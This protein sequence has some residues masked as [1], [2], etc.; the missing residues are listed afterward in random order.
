ML[1]I[2][3]SFIFYYVYSLHLLFSVKLYFVVKTK[4]IKK[5]TLNE[6]KI[7]LIK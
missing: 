6:K 1:Q 4:D 7:I 5:N 3:K 2:I